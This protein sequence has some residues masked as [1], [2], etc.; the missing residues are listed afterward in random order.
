MDSTPSQSPAVHS[1]KPWSDDELR[2]LREAPTPTDAWPILKTTRTWTAVLHKHAD[3]RRLET[4][5]D[6][7]QEML[8]NAPLDFFTDVLDMDAALLDDGDKAPVSPCAQPKK[9]THPNRRRKR[10]MEAPPITDPVDLPP[11]AITTN[12]KRVVVGMGL[13]APSPEHRFG[14]IN[15]MLATHRD[16]RTEAWDGMPLMF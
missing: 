16:A 8:T 14:A 5:H 2:A 3:E 1:R 7:T 9:V 13:G 6:L 12:V 10:P 11:R 15:A 4:P